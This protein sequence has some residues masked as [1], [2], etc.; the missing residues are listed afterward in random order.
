MVE[1]GEILTDGSANL[2]ELFKIGGREAAE[3]YISKEISR[4]YELQGASISRKHIEVIVRKMFS[5]RRIK[6]AGDT[7]FTVGE[8]VENDEFVIENK[9]AKEDGK[10]EAGAEVELFGISE[11]A[12]TS[13]SFLS[14]ASFQN[15]TRVLIDAAVKGKVD[16]LKGLKENVIV[17]RLIPAGT[18]MKEGHFGEIIEEV[19]GGGTEE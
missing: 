17:G 3:N 13:A 6:T 18:G 10:E 12:H 11:V 19:A 14:A 8:V 4:I 9:Q 5:R 15:T 7:R 2:N 1:R 16:K